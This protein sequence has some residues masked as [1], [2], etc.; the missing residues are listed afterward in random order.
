MGSNTKW[1][2]ILGLGVLCLLVA[3]AM[4][5]PAMAFADGDGSIDSPLVVNQA[6]PWSVDGTLTPVTYE[7]SS[8]GNEFWYTIPLT[9]GQ[10]LKLT[11]TASSWDALPGSAMFATW[12]TPYYVEASYP[13]DTVGSLSL[14]APRTGDYLLVMSN[15][16]VASTYT[17]DAQIV[18]PVNFSLWGFSAPK[19][20]KRLKTFTVS[21]RLSPKYNGLTPPIKFVLQHKVGSKWKAY[22]TLT[23]LSNATGTGFSAKFKLK[24]GTYRVRSSFADLAHPH[25]KY[26]VWRTVKVK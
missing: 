21:D 20:A 19:T 12:D 24:A 15:D 1:L 9:A 22:K 13:G 26:T 17:I 10:T 25:A 3:G 7:D 5:L 4:L 2:R 23:G 11:T 14:M 6:L 16:T 18:P 8:T